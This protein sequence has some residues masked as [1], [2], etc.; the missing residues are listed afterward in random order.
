ML[1]KNSIKNLTVFFFFQSNE[2]EEGKTINEKG[3]AAPN[4]VYNN[5]FTFH[6]YHKI[7]KFVQHSL[8]SKL[9]DLEEFKDKLELFYHD[10][11]EFK[12]NNK[13]QMKDFKKRKVGLTTAHE[14][15]DKLL[16]IYKTQYDKLK[17]AYKKRIKV[18]NIHENIPI[19]LFLDE[20]DL[21]LMP[22]LGDK[23]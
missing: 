1:Q 5:Y 16:N 9:N 8:D 17:K 22:T 23:N 20:D 18:Q 4:L 6:K 15:Y 2:Y 11:I 12:P 21:P 13:E 10:T 14:L 7:N 3:R 19:D